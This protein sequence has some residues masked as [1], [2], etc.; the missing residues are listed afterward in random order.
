MQVEVHKNVL[1]EPLINKSDLVISHCGAG[2]LLESLRAEHTQCIAV[3]NDSLMNNHQMEL[4]D[5]LEQDN[6]IRKATPQNVLTQI[7][8]LLA[9]G[10]QT[11][12]KY[13]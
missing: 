9:T 3:V 4:A 12:A 2:I 1:L 7:R 8:I 6:Y 13:P 11:L 5:R 10:K